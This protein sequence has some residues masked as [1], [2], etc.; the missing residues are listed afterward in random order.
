VHEHTN[1]E[2]AFSESWIAELRHLEL[3]TQGRRSAGQEFARDFRLGCCCGIEN[4]KERGSVK[5]QIGEEQSID[6]MGFRLASCGNRA[7]R[8]GI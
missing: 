5:A 2:I 4:G 7:F 8:S 1:P 6:L 3:V